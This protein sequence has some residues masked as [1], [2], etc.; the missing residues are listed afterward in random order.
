MLYQIGV[1]EVSLG[2]AGLTTLLTVY[3]W[4]LK[5]FIAGAIKHEYDKKLELFKGE[6]LRKEKAAVVA[7]F[8]AEWTH[9]RGSDTKRLNQL[10]WELSIYLP[11][12]L[13]LELNLLSK[14]SPD[15]KTA[16][17]LI[18]AARDYLLGGK[19]PVDAGSITHFNHPD[20]KSM[21]SGSRGS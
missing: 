5:S 21:V 10:L 9:I 2:L 18:V 1:L 13:V 16:P 6:R 7:E 3:G 15:A 4:W 19:D 20:N 14:G 12:D 11:S 8:F 17:A